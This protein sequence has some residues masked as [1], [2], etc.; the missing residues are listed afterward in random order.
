M[1]IDAHSGE[2]KSTWTVSETMKSKNAWLDKGAGP[3]HVG[4]Q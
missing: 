1:L 4:P 2:T 3:D